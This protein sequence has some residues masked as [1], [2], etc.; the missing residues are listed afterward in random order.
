MAKKLV[1]KQD[2][3]IFTPYGRI[4]S[5]KTRNVSLD[6]SG[7]SASVSRTKRN[8]DVVT[9]SV[10]TS[11][12]YAGTTATKSKVVTNKDGDRVSEK[13]KSI[14]PKAA[15]RKIDRVINNVGRNAND[16]ASASYKKGGSVKKKKK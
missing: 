9:R 10:N 5:P 12:G 14:S 4:K 8:G 1:K 13:T 3:G 16:T 6:S 15:D 2:G 7:N 11:N